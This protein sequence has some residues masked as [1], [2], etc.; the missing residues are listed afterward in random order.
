MDLVGPLPQSEGYCYLFTVIDQFSR[1][2]E[3][4]PLKDATAQSC[5]RALIQVWISRYGIP[6]R[7]VS[8][9]GAQF[10]GSLWKELCASLAIEHH[11]TTSYHPQANGLVERF[12]RQ[13]KGALKARLRGPHWTD[14]LPIVLLVLMAR[15]RRHYASPAD[16][17]RG[18]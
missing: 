16:L 7:I 6:D 10:T 8:D 12:H 3:A 1:W 9:R 11:P 17:R 2:P 14:E 4:V 15:G 13:L 18:P 5:V